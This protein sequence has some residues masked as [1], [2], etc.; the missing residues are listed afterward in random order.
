MSRDTA[1]I[2]SN[3][4]LLGHLTILQQNVK[5]NFDI[6]YEELKQERKRLE[7]D[8]EKLRNS[9]SNFNIK[10]K[11]LAAEREKLNK[12][13]VELDN[14][15]KLR[16]IIFRQKQRIEA[17]K[18]LRLKKLLKRERKSSKAKIKKVLLENIKLSTE[19]QL[20]RSEI[21]KKIIKVVTE[22]DE[23]ESVEY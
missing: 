4:T 5:R 11:E 20:L 15:I 8:I 18:I 21:C 19:L 13:R 7:I 9:K 12:E 17:R 23:H 16:N 22:S 6:K 3:S 1:L 14:K 2:L 10:E